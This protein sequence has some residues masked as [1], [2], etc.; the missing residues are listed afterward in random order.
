MAARNKSFWSDDELLSDPTMKRLASVGTHALQSGKVKP[1]E[2]KAMAENMGILPKSDDGELPGQPNLAAMGETSPEA[3]QAAVKMSK[4]GSNPLAI[5]TDPSQDVETSPLSMLAGAPN[6]SPNSVSKMMEQVPLDAS[7]KIMKGVKASDETSLT[8]QFKKSSNR[9]ISK[10]DDTYRAD[11]GKKQGVYYPITG[12]E[13]ATDG[14][15]NPIF[16]NASGQRVTA[17]TPG[18]QPLPSHD[19]PIHD[20]SR[21]MADPNDPI[22]KQQAGIAR[23]QDLL[24]MTN[25][26]QSGRNTM[27]LSPLYKLADYLNAQAGRPTNLASSYKQPDERSDELF[28]NEDELQKRSEEI[29]KAANAR[30]TKGGS[31]TDLIAQLALAKQMSGIDTSHGSALDPQRRL[32]EMRFRA[33][34]AVPMKPAMQRMLGSAFAAKTELDLTNDKIVGPV[35]KEQFEELQTLVRGLPAAL[36]SSGGSRLTGTERKEMTMNSLEKD[37][38]RL[39]DTYIKNGVN[40]IPADDPQ[41]VHFRGLVA[42][43]KKNFTGIYDGHLDALGAGMSRLLKRPGNED[44]KED[45]ENY[46]SK[47]AQMG[48]SMTTNGSTLPPSA[49]PPVTSRPRSST[50]RA[51]KAASGGLPSMADI[52]AELAR[53]KAAK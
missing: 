33:A 30:D 6:P 27:D 26:A 44:L 23:M 50:P 9:L 11:Q 20:F 8:N 49:T 47:L 40:T 2:A 34:Q 48:S 5:G 43:I 17:N 16:V 21:P 13:Q 46:A 1:D 7:G 19:D 24:K 25:S 53:R 14:Q 18:A 32:D 36:A 10:P 4:S 12:Y 15:G 22:Q 42:E 38:G 28:K 41:L 29:L 51:P 31:T 3:A 35:S 52:D 37:L 45:W 39:W